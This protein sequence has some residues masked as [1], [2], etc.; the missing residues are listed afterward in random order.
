MKFES[1]NLHDDILRGLSDAGFERCTPIQEQS[2]PDCLAGKD[3]IAQSQT[4]TGKTAVFLLTIFSRLLK[5]TGEG[6]VGPRALIMEPTRELAHQVHEDAKKLGR[7]LPF[8]SAAIYGGVEYEKQIKTLKGGVEIVAATP[9]RMIDLYKSRALS[10]DSIEV[11]VIDEADR[12][13]DMGFAPDINYIAGRLPRKKPRQTMLFSAT[14]DRNVHRLSSRHMS[15]EAVTVEIEPEQ[16]TV[17]SIDQKILYVS[18]EEKFGVLMALLRRPDVERTIIF[19][20]MKR[21]AEML[22][23]K[24]KGNG[25]PVKVLTG[26]VSQARRQRVIEGMKLG[27]VEL[28]VATDVAARGLHIEGITHIINYD[29]PE[30]A[31]NYVHRIGRTARAGKQ[32]KAYSLVCEDHVLAL[33]EIEKFIEQKIEKEWIDESEIPEDKS[34][35]YRPARRGPVPGGRARPGRKKIPQQGTGPSSRSGVAERGGPPRKRARPAPAGE[36]G[37]SR[38]T[39]VARRGGGPRDGGKEAGTVEAGPARAVAVAEPRRRGEAGGTDG[40]APAP[41]RRRRPRRARRPGP[42]KP[43][44]GKAAQ[45]TGRSGQK[46]AQAGKGKTTAEARRRPQSRGRAAPD[47]KKAARR[48]GRGRDE[49]RGAQGSKALQRGG[50]R[51]T[52]RPGAARRTDYS[53]TSAEAATAPIKKEGLLKRALSIFRRRG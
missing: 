4:G 40:G 22:D 24:L 36:D 47:K 30:D 11:F 17:S 46:D 10:L 41:R 23:W 3:I 20:N 29:L 53:S 8:G 48:G 49:G 1:L 13:F 35:R 38:R 43:G 12:M 26:D 18:N 34:G 52:A 44:D 33:P 2:L 7:Y 21:T 42:S 6:G 31:A 14:I 45:A 27:R 19:T 37:G 25:F 50:R 16:I 39:R 32:G 5:E 28:L 15:S 9:G 51:R